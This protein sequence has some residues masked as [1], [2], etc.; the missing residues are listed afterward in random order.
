MEITQTT[1]IPLLCAVLAMMVGYSI[2][3][4]QAVQ[5][6][7]S[8]EEAS[9][10]RGEL[11][12]VGILKFVILSLATLNLYGLYWFWR[13]WRRHQFVD[14]VDISPFWRAF[15]A[16][17]WLYSLF[18]VVNSKAKLRWP[19]WIGI[20]VAVLYL[21]ANFGITITEWLNTSIWAFLLISAATTIV[22]VPIVFFVNQIN[23]PALVAEQSRFEYRHWIALLVSVP[24]LIMD[25]MLV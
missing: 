2:L 8:E 20:C 19:D 23:D 13:C 10:G 24:Y 22:L 11:H 9:S 21:V 3:I 5:T 14:S 1:E 16:P 12:P 17:L 4:Y 18:E 6:V 25:F 15:F 7:K